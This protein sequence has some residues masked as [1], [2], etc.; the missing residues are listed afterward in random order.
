MDAVA[1]LQMRQ[2]ELFALMVCPRCRSP[3][4]WR[5]AVEVFGV[6]I[7]ADLWCNR[8]AVR[9][10]VV[11]NFR[12]SFLDREMDKRPPGPRPAYMPVAW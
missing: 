4:T 9:V 3:L 12:A 11:T 10:G 5:D 1:A 6:T 2:S 7:E 8:C